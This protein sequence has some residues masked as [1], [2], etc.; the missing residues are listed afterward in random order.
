MA[1]KKGF[2]L[3][4]IMLVVAI[5]GLLATIGI[6]VI[7]GAY[8]KA[9]ATTMD[10]NI[11]AVE[12]AKGVLTLPAGLLPGAIGLTPEDDFDDNA[13]ANLCTALQID[14]LDALT[15]SGQEISVGTLTLRASY[16]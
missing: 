1:G 3:V 7:L 11:A 12:K 6:P 9:Q 4:E 8:A 10:S 15:V 5:I 2:T 16:N 14:D 13:I